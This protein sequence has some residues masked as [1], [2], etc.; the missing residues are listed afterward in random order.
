MAGASRPAASSRASPRLARVAG[1]G[2]PALAH[3]RSGQGRQARGGIAGAA[4]VDEAIHGPLAELL[5]LTQ[6]PGLEGCLAAATQQVGL[7]ERFRLQLECG[8]I[9]TDRLARRAEC[10]RPR[11]RR[12]QQGPGP[13]QHHRLLGVVR[14]ARLEGV[15]EML[16][17]DAGDGIGTVLVLEVGSDRE[18]LG[19]SVLA[20]ERAVG[21]LPHEG[22]QEA[23]LAELGRSR[24][25]LGLD[26]ALADQSHERGIEVVRTEVGE[27]DQT[28]LVGRTG[29]ARWR[30]A[31]RAAPWR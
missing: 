21:D 3:H 12:G 24:V 5:G 20:G 7:L 31:P 27:L 13:V 17:D 1:L 11:G 18:V 6:L 8:E 30:P 10:G 25:D 23:V 14:S 19:S 29:P 4:E 15:E 22:L 16:G 26:H 2:D 28:R 9:S